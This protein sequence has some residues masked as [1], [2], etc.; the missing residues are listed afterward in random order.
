MDGEGAVAAEPAHTQAVR[1]RRRLDHDEDAQRAAKAMS[2]TQLGEL[3]ATRQ[4]LEGA[5]VAPD[6]VNVETVDFFY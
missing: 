1:R 4:A 2:L 6:D 5:P 3:S